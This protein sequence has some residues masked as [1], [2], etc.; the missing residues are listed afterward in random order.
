MFTTY[1]GRETTAITFLTILSANNVFAIFQ[2][3]L[4]SGRQ[5]LKASRLPPAV[6]LIRIDVRSSDCKLINNLSFRDTSHDEH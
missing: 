2:K 3:K 4:K 6:G 5:K 1:Q